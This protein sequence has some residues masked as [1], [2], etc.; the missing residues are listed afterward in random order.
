MKPEDLPNDKHGIFMKRYAIKQ[1]R[2]QIMLIK[3]SMEGEE[4]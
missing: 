4:E 2:M 1:L 3:E